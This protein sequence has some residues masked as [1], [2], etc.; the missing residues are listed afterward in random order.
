MVQKE[1][2][3]GLIMSKEVLV[4]MVSL[5]IATSCLLK[6]VPKERLREVH[7][8]FLFCQSIAWI[9]EFMQVHFGLVEFPFREFQNATKMSFSLHYFVLPS[10]GVFFILLFPLKKGIMRTITHYI[11]FSAALP[12]YTSLVEH[13]TAIIEFKRWNW[14][15]AVCANFILLWII[16]KFV[17]WFRKELI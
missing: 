10:F 14:L 6:Y 17:F 13:F 1:I 3:C 2:N 15:I 11:I 5:F 4:I 16:K 12:T 7:I 8:T 9:F